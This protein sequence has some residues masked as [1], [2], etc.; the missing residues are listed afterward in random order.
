MKKVTIFLMLFLICFAS[1]EASTIKEYVEYSSGEKDDGSIYLDSYEDY[2][3]ILKDVDEQEVYKK[4]YEQMIQNQIEEF[5]KIE[6]SKTVKAKVLETKNVE[7]YY[8][9]DSTGT[10]KIKYQPLNVQILEGEYKDKEVEVSYILTADSYENIK[11][12]AIRKNQNINVILQEESGDLYAYATTIDAAVDRAGYVLALAIVTI[13]V[14]LICLR[15]SGLKVLTLLILL[16]D[17]I[18]LIVVPNILE[19]TSILWLTIVT[20]LLYMFVT[21]V[22][23]NGLKTKI[24]P[25][26]LTSI[27]VTLVLTIGLIIFGNMTNLCG[28]MYEI[29]SMIEVFP[30]G[31][32]DFYVLYLASFILMSI[33][34]TIDIASEGMKLYDENGNKNAKKLLK[35]YTANKMPTTIGILLVMMIPK[36]LYI[37]MSKYNFTEIINSEM[38]L[39]DIIRILF[40]TLA[41]VITKEVLEIMRKIFVE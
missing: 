39:T 26:I 9:N 40:L 7:E 14:V 20:S 1:V 28:I 4:D 32:I 24:I 21:A 17:L 11:V 41:I 10:Y 35:E 2:E 16:A 25:V 19:G 12:P 23:K 37:L 13:L 33:I 8:S 6:K 36:Y 15:I 29:T 27:S 18:I 38:L 5:E 3:K 34:V 22:L 31:T 30:K